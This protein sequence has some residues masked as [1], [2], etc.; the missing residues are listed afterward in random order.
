MIQRLLLVFLL[1][2]GAMAAAGCASPKDGDVSAIPWNRPQTW[3]GSA[4]F[5]GFRPPGQSY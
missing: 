5:G 1:A 2:L 4:G 3:E